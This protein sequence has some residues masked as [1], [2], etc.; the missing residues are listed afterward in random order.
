MLGTNT[1]QFNYSIFRSVLWLLFLSLGIP[2]ILWI[3]AAI[4]MGV[5][6][7]EKTNISKLLESPLALGGFSLVSALIILPM[8]KR[9]TKQLDKAGLW[10]FL[11]FKAIDKSTLFKVLALGAVYYGLMSLVLYLLGI[12]TPQFMLDIKAQTNTFFTMVMVVVA[13]CLVAPFMEEII[14]RGVGYGRLKNSKLGIVGAIVLPSLLFTASHLQY[15]MVDMLSILQ[16]ALL[17][18]YIRYKTD[19]IWYCILLHFQLNVLSSIFLFIIG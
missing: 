14:F 2:I 17:L 16:L 5:N 7:I 19:N 12:P 11:G 15:E 3:I 10:Q 8:L 6:G 4:M 18:G 9:V 1:T 13:I